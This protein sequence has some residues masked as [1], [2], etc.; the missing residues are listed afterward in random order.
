MLC[1]IGRSFG[2]VHDSDQLSARVQIS[3]DNQRQSAPAQP[4]KKRKL[5]MSELTDYELD[6]KFPIRRLQGHT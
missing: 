1:R 5:P 2:S 3:D 6:P 4:R